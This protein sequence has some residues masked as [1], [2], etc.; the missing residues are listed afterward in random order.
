[1]SANGLDRDEILA[2]ERAVNER[3]RTKLKQDLEKISN[4]VAQHSPR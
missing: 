2:A 4:A 3:Y 1:V